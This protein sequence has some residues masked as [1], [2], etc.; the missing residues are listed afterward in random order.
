MQHKRRGSPVIWLA[1]AL[2]LVGIIVVAILLSHG[3]VRVVELSPGQGDDDV[4]ITTPIRITF[5]TDMDEATVKDRFSIEPEVAGEL[6]WEGRTLTFR[7]RSA[8]SPD[9]NYEITLEAGAVSKRG[10]STFS[11]M[12]SSR[13]PSSMR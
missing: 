8:L 7:A 5:S 1:V 2:A 11:R 12:G 10:R 13:K 9:T 6:E 3:A 4:P